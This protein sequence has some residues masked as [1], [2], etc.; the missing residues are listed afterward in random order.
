M[1]ILHEVRREALR[2]GC[3]ARFDSII[4]FGRAVIL[5]D[6][7]ESKAALDRIMEH[8]GSEG[9]FEYAGEYFAKTAIIRIVIEQM[10][11][12]HHD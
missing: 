12:K 3:T 10:T 11:G 4:G 2:C 8:Y 5:E 1:D 6:P 7:G 9:P